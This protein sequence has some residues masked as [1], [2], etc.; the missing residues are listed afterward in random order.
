MC[1]LYAEL[2]LCKHL[3][4]DN[5]GADAASRIFEANKVNL[6][7]FSTLGSSLLKNDKL[8]VRI[9]H[10]Y[11]PWDEAAPII[12]GIV[13]FGQEQVFEPQGMIAVDR[14]EKNLDGDPS[15]AIVPPRGSWRLWPFSV[16]KSKTLSTVQS[17]PE[18]TTQ[19]NQDVAPVRSQ[20][21]IGNDELQRAKFTKKKVR[22]LAPTS[23]ELASLNLK[24]GQNVITFSFSTAMLGQQQVLFVLSPSLVQYGFLLCML[25]FISI[26]GRC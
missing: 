8:V 22:S 20:S 13:C 24:E 17:V 10:R 18:S 26:T 14:D 23:E 5:M 25:K 21:L 2:S 7:K 6:E 11:F 19:E 4:F 15:G 9:G 16:R 12:L 1:M 3:L